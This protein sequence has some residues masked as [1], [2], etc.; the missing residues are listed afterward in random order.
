MF[1]QVKISVI[2]LLGDQDVQLLNKNNTA[3]QFLYQ[4]KSL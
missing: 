3:M 2:A 4:N 1:E